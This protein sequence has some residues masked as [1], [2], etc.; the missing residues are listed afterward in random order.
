MKLKDNAARVKQIREKRRSRKA[1]I[2]RHTGK[3]AKKNLFSLL[4]FLIIAL[5]IFGLYFLIDFK[6]KYWNGKDKFSVVINSSGNAVSIVTFDPARGEI[7]SISIPGNTQV[8]VARGLGRWK[9][10]SVWKLGEE[11]ALDGSLLTETLTNQLKL[12]VYIWADHASEGLASRDLV[13][14]LKAVALP[15][16]TNMGVGDKIKIALFNLSVKNAARKSINLED[17]SYLRQSVLDDG[18][19]GYIATSKYPSDL[20][21]VFSDE[22]ISQDSLNVAIT[23][24]SG[25]PEVSLALGQIIEVLGAKTA[26]IDRE[27]VRDFNCEVSGEDVLVNKIILLFGCTKT[28][29]VESSIFDVNLK[30]GTY[31]AK[32]F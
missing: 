14:M 32:D 3:I 22:K 28:K 16:K 30:I 23:D 12:P 11:E 25:D 26:A 9:L 29:N 4:R 6:T 17:T 5:F 27:G 31:F 1:K 18:S 21:P 19:M 2:Q 13:K 8:E 20:L 15:Y 10:K 24:C 7:D